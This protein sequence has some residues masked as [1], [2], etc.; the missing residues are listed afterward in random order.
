MSHICVTL[1][2]RHARIPYI[3]TEI[4]DKLRAFWSF[5]PKGLWYMPQYKQTKMMLDQKKVTLLQLERLRR[6]RPQTKKIK[7]RIAVITENLVELDAKLAKAWNGRISMVK[8]SAVP[9]GL[10]RATW[11]EAEKACGVTFSA[12]KERQTVSFVPGIPDAGVQYRHQNACVDAM[13][14]AVPKGGGII[15]A[16]TSSGKTGIAARFFSKVQCDCLFV[17][18]QID[19]L[20]QQ[21]KE[22][23]EWTHEAVG[24]VGESKFQPARITVATI[25]TLNLYR[26]RS[27]FKRWFRGVD[28]M[29]VDELH[30]QMAKRNFNVLQKIAPVAVFGMTA[31][32]QLTQKEVCM[33]AYS[34]AG[35]VIFRFPIVEGVKRGVLAK[36]YAIQLLFASQVHSEHSL[37][38][39][40][41]I[42]YEEELGV[43]VLQNDLKL[44]A[45]KALAEELIRQKR[46]L[47]I[48]VDRMSH[49]TDVHDR[50]S[51]IPH[52][53]ICGDVPIEERQKA[54][55]MFEDE[56]L[57]LILSTKVFKKGVSI[58]RIDA[59][60][61]L[62][63]WKSKNDAVQKFG[64]GLRL[65]ADKN[66]LIYID[67]GTA[68]HGRFAAK[69]TSRRRA[70]QKAGI[71]VTVAHDISSAIGAVSAVRKFIRKVTNGNHKG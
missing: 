22:I 69:A 6:R 5:S 48:L 66:E 53:L 24:F 50:L 30:E 15:L 26:Q 40:C 29:V 41:G 17:V 1:T 31:T 44:E 7:L 55:T 65:H 43:E 32:L 60:I 27:D 20:Y 68:G 51:S 46:H 56:D 62:A 37:E 25:Q 18:D 19:L 12:V 35:P 38:C 36:G 67:F 3:S 57:N 54:K 16:A 45:C 63:E 28:I 23:A 70:L 33:K 2:N 10:F 49:L 59:M 8:D 21:Q 14:R 47:L 4:F 42:G 58:K 11:K 52:A 34:F 13:I 39:D 64:R 71:D 61:D 9:A